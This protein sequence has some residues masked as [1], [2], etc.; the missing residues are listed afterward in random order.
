MRREPLL[1]ALSPN[2][3]G[4]L[5]MAFH[6]PRRA[7]LAARSL[8]PLPP[9][10]SGARSSRESAPRALLRRLCNGDPLRVAGRSRRRLAERAYFVDPRHL[11]ARSLARIAR[12]SSGAGDLEVGTRALAERLERCID[13]SIFEL[14]D[15]QLR[16]ERD[17]VPLGR[18]ESA[19]FYRFLAPRLGVDP[20]HCRRGC[21]RLNAL[22]WEPRRAFLE[23]AVHGRSIAEAAR[24]LGAP[25]GEAHRWLAEARAALAAPIDED[26]E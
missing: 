5:P 10:A 4:I 15:L 25:L 22:Q 3:S 18:S 26:A 1:V 24:E 13:R 2:L 23:V 16:E 8:R 6:A 12:S 14:I 17:A 21:V 7:T 20:R 11:L 9:D 19:A